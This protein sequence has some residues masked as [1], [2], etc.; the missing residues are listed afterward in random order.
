MKNVSLV[1]HLA[2]A[3]H[4]RLVPRCATKPVLAP[5]LAFD[6]KSKARAYISSF[7]HS[8]LQMKSTQEKPE[9]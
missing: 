4:L 9:N 3:C 8:T 2:W 7:H 5:R 6:V 1:G